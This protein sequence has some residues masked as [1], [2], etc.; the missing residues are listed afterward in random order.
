M[1]IIDIHA[2]LQFRLF[3]ADREEVIKRTL[4]EGC[5]VINVGVD[6]EDSK[7]AIA[8]AESREGFWATAGLH[9][10]DMSNEEFNHDEFLKLVKH[11][12]VAAIGEC[13]LD[14]YRI[15]YN[16]SSIKEKQKD[17]F[18]KHIELA[19]EVK[20]PL[21]LHLRGAYDDAID[22]LKSYPDIRGNA[23]F[24]AGTWEQAKKLFDMGI[25]I[26]FDGPITFARDYDETIKN[27]PLDMLMAETDAPF[28][29]PVPYR[30]K[31][32]EPLYVREVIKKIAEIKGLSYEEVTAA[33]TVNA[34]RVFGL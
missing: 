12:K 34:H 19:L 27:A 22:I 25:T 30:G 28:A 23:H 3:D 1:N 9:P 20:K 15:K 21:M 31:R 29:A 8:L 7:K 18:K 33:T 24:F 26:S 2:H 5:G 13:G 4:A 11:P 32:N 16:V 10:T 14:Y 6:L 17:V